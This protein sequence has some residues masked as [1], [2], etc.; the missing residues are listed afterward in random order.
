MYEAVEGIRLRWIDAEAEYDRFRLVVEESTKQALQ[1][2]G[3]SARVTSRTK[4]IDSLVR[5]ALKQIKEGRSPSFD[6]IV[7]KVGVRAVVRFKEEVGEAVGTLKSVFH[8][9]RLEYKSEGQRLNEFGYRS[10]HMDIELLRDHKSYSLYPTFP[11]E[12]QVRTLAQDLWADMAHEL[13]YKSVLRDANPELQKTIDRR[14]YILSALVESADM[15]FSRINEEII[16]AQGAGR[17]LVLRAL[18]R[19]YFKYTSR[20]YDPEFSLEVID[21]LW[22][23]NPR[24]IPQLTQDLAQF[25]EENSAKL[26]HIFS[27]QANNPLRSAFLFQPEVFLLFESLERHSLAL[28]ETWEQHFPASELEKLATAWGVA[29]F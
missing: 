25:S 18:E 10:C 9:T 29:V 12:L 7:D 4:K 23:I 11:A 20:A 17:L 6:S 2:A 16:G 14:I 19:E 24:P 27:D 21:M 22:P 15:E 28:E 13:S 3:L 5:K 8:C 1:R 26:N